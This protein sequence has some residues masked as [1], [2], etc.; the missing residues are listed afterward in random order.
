M[1]LTTR[2][3]NIAV[4]L[5]VNTL[6]WN[7]LYF[8]KKYYRHLQIKLARI[9]LQFQTKNLLL[10]MRLETFFHRI[11]LSL[12]I[13]IVSCLRMKGRLRKE[14]YDPAKCRNNFSPLSKRKSSIY[15]LLGFSFQQH[16]P[17]TWTNHQLMNCK[18]KY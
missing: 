12:I 7:C 14:W 15:F 17:L 1:Q 4:N 16:Q 11:F 2:E 5:H 9:W 3:C 6:F 18:G 8:K 10:L 13:P